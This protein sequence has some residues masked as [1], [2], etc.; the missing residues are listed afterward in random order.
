LA[1]AG[2]LRGRRW[3]GLEAASSI[4]GETQPVTNAVD[5]DGRQIGVGDDFLGTDEPAHAVTCID[6]LGR[7]SLPV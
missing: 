5:D 2:R 6:D 1:T 4:R 7:I 3:A